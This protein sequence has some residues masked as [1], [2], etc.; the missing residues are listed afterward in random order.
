MIMNIVPRHVVRLAALGTFAM[1]LPLVAS[2]HDFENGATFQL[3]MGPMSAAQKN[4]GTSA[5]SDDAPVKP[6]RHIKHRHPHHAS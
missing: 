1:A 2:A 3:A 4:Q 5:T 6:H